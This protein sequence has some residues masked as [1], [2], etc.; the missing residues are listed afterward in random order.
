MSSASININ[1]DFAHWRLPLASDCRHNFEF[2]K[3]WEVSSVAGDEPFSFLLRPLDAVRE[4]GIRLSVLGEPRSIDLYSTLPRE[5][6]LSKRQWQLV[7]RIRGSGQGTKSPRLLG[8]HLLRAWS[9]TKW[10]FDRR[11]LPSAELSERWTYLE[12][13][14]GSPSSKRPDSRV[15]RLWNVVRNNI[16]QWRPRPYPKAR[17]ALQF[18]GQGVIEIES[19]SIRDMQGHMGSI[20]GPNESREPEGAWIGP[21]VER[22]SKEMDFSLQQEISHKVLEGRIVACL[23]RRVLGWV[24]P[25]PSE[26]QASLC[27]DGEKVG[28][29]RP[30]DFSGAEK[31]LFGEHCHHGFG[32]TLALTEPPKDNDHLISILD[33]STGLRVKD[34]TVRM[35]LGDGLHI[36]H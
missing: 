33:E 24:R 15:A 27:I 12:V 36:P 17:L 5:M 31:A 4:L 13:S 19:C 32:V 21:R 30:S 8:A 22:N 11:L 26:V 10:V 14:F 23:N 2:C 25:G 34:S 20:S 3:S 35:R 18:A 28:V 16:S 6:D 1:P 7:M 9:P 29:I